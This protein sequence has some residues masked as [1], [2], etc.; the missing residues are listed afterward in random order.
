MKK[1]SGNGRNQISRRNFVK[2][3]GVVVAG[4]SLNLP[5]LDKITSNENVTEE[6]SKIV[7]YRTLGRTGFKVSDISSGGARSKTTNVFRYA[8]DKGIN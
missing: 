6:S 2:A 5:G 8:Y 1:K 7:Q 4:T 3:G